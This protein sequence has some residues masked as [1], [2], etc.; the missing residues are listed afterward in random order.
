MRS[1]T[2]H[3]ITIGDVEM[4]IDGRVAIQGRVDPWQM[5]RLTIIFYR[6][7]PVAVE[8]DLQIAIALGSAELLPVLLAE[9]F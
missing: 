7:L 6:K 3:A 9:I 8:F 4:L 2:G 1:L 5:I